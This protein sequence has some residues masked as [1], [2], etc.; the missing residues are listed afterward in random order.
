MERYPEYHFSMSQ[1]QTYA[2]LKQDD[3][4]LYARLKQRVAEG[5]FEPVG[6]MWLEPDC[7]VPSGESLARQLNHGARLF[8]EEFGAINHVVW[9]PDVFGYSAALPQLMR[10]AGINCFMTTKIS[11]N[12]F[13][14]MPCD[15]FRWR[16]IDG[17]EVLAHFVTATDQPVKPNPTEAQFYTYNGDMTPGEVFGTWNH[18]RQKAV[19]D[20][21]LYIYGYGDGGGGPTEEML[22][23]ARQMADLPGFPQVRPG[24]VE[25][26]FERLY[27]R[28]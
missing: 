12:Q 22:E 27:Q 10:L 2:F 28:A 13:N 14:R 8:Q 15:T 16:G 25:Q 26:F 17:T 4:E 23:L 7:N 19:S 3:P 1:P 24:R 6:M 5:R 11:W 9:L 21:A 20:E 18:Y